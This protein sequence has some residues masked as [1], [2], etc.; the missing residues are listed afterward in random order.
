MNF[1]KEGNFKVPVRLSFSL[2]YSLSSKIKK[3]AIS[4]NLSVGEFIKKVLIE[5]I[6]K[7]EQNENNK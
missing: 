2:E 3:V 7:R 4:E 1:R 5:Y 6:D